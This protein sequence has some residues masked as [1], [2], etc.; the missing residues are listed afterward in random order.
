MMTGHRRVRILFSNHQD[1][2][3]IVSETDV[4]SATVSYV[5]LLLGLKLPI[6]NTIQRKARTHPILRLDGIELIVSSKIHRFALANL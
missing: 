4:N 5:A 2:C 3:R 6:K 1:V